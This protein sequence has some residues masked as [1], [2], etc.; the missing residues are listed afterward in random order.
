MAHKLELAYKRKNEGIDAHR[1][2]TFDI[3]KQSINAVFLTNVGA[4]SA[5]VTLYAA[6]ANKSGNLPFR[7]HD[8]A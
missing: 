6:T 8:V 7:A 4:A 5:L 2:L 1:T 3:I